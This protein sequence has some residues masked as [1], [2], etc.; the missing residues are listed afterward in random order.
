M[1]AGHEGDVSNS[2]KAMERNLI[3]VVD[4]NGLYLLTQE[5]YQNVFLKITKS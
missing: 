2:A 3:L 1:S 5:P 4:A